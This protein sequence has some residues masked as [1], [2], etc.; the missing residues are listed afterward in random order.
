MSNAK[1]S[2][3]GG[4]SSA[5]STAA[6][7]G[8]A[9]LYSSAPD[10]VATIT[11][12]RPRRLNGWSK[13]VIA[14]MS[15]ALKRASDSPDVKVVILTAVGRYYGAGADFSDQTS[16]P[17]RPSKLVANA[18]ATNKAIFGAYIACTK[19]IIVAAQGPMLG[20]AVTTAC[21]LSEAVL[22]T[23][24]VTLQVP[25]KQLGLAP[26]GCAE[27]TW[28]LRLRGGQNDADRLLKE[29]QKVTA[30]EALSMGLIDEILPDQPSLLA[31]AN[32]RAREWLA[33]H[34][35]SS[36]GGA[37]V[38]PRWVLVPAYQKE[39]ATHFD[40]DA[41]KFVAK[42]HAVNEAES[43]RLARSIMS[44]SFLAMQSRLM[45]KKGNACLGWT[46]WLMAPFGPL[47]A[48]L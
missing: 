39:I 47:L 27:Y 10:G 36:G 9:V 22:A 5:A 40:G 34:T 20:G 4:A 8:P 45:A 42:L 30:H 17:M 31:R 33:A 7:D 41:A 32:A 48:N 43:R 46:F 23:P 38:V 44:P 3:A 12:N 11:F 26:E 15:A 16:G 2:K 25:F 28:P 21:S 19:P 13:D 37:A 14:A 6:A 24:N 29:G 35:A 18:Y 1:G